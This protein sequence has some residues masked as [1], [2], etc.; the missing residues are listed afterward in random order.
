MNWRM[1]LLRKVMTW[2]RIIM[3]LRKDRMSLVMAIRLDLMGI[4][5]IVNEIWG[6]VK[7]F[8]VLG[9]SVDKVVKGIE[10]I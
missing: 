5:F 8:N 1:M 9:D 10:R 2:L 6:K 4:G 3:D 7:V